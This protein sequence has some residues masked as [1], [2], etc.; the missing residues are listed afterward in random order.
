MSRLSVPHSTVHPTVTTLPNGI[1]LIVQ[2][3]DV[4]DTVSVYGHIKNREQTEA[5]ADKQGVDDVLERLFE[6]GTQ[7]MN[8]LQF[9]AGARRHWRDRE[10]GDRFQ[11]AGA[12]AEIRRAG[13]NCWPTMN[14]IRH[15]PRR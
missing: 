1:T 11:P 4:S 9:Q 10:R 7:S 5:P 3:E 8:R 2:P 13:S 14:C 12:G 6:F 15:C